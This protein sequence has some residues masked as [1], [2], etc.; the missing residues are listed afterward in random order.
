MESWSMGPVKSSLSLWRVSER[1]RR[2]NDL[3]SSWK[4]QRKFCLSIEILNRHSSISTWYPPDLICNSWM[5][6]LN[7]WLVSDRGI[8]E[9]KGIDLRRI[10]SGRSGSSIRGN[11][12]DD[13]VKWMSEDQHR[14]KQEEWRNCWTTVV[15]LI[16][17]GV[18]HCNY[19]VLRPVSGKRQKG[20]GKIIRGGLL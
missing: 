9:S 10:E 2:R 17:G 4:L 5:N 8:N 7:R 3:F 11:G 20:S 18:W 13:I 15:L 12:V 1:F 19:Q 6:C 16:V 14:H